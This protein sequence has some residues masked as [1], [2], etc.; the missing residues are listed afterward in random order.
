M[1]MVPFVQSKMDGGSLPVWS[2]SK[3]ADGTAADVHHCGGNKGP[4]WEPIR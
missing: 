3:Q 4:K 2:R 1:A